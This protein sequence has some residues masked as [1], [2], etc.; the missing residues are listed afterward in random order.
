MLRDIVVRVIRIVWRVWGLILDKLVRECMDRIPKFI[1]KN[2]PTNKT[3]SQKDSKQP[4]TQI[5][6]QNLN[7]NF[8]IHSTTQANNSWKIINH[9]CKTKELSS[10]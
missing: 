10:T 1:S 2:N 7:Y 5:L 3:I 4:K 8:Y 6:K 9:S